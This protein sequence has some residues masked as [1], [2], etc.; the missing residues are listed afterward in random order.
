[1]LAEMGDTNFLLGNVTKNTY[2]E[3]FNNPALQTIIQD[4]CAESL[5]NCSECAYLPYCGC[6]PL[7]NYVTQKDHY[8]HRPTNDFCYKQMEI[9]NYLFKYI[10]KKDEKVLK[11]F[12]SWINYDE[13]LITIN[14]MES[15][16]D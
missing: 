12:W 3:V 14:N 4:S 2:S 10:N 16:N 11:I 5:T 6:D 15:S 1:M 7:F 9:Y 13:E 8:G